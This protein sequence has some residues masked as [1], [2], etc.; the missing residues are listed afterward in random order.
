MTDT[1][2]DSDQIL[3]AARRSLSAQR[4]GGT[5]RLGPG[6]SIGKGS[7]QAK[8]NHW[9]KRG[10]YLVVTLVGLMIATGVFWAVFGPIDFAGVMALALATLVAIGLFAFG[11]SPK[12][13][14]RDEL[15]LGSPQQMVTKTELW[16]ESQRAALPPPAVQIV[17]QL[18]TQLDAL[19]LQLETIDAAHPAMN[20]V[21][22][23]VG[24]YIPET[25]DNYRKI[26]E[27]LREEE[28]AGKTANARLVESL[29]K[30]S[31]EVERVTRRLAEGALDDLA[32]KSRYLDYRY[33]GDDLIGDMRGDDQGAGVPLPDFDAV[34]N[35]VK[36]PR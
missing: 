4:A 20:E 5:H 6:T 29:G 2:G 9:L 25:I 27:H 26:P 21:R 7:A 31:G 18:G 13:P 3:S 14:K 11:P 30:L 22:E 15:K 8:L 19:G 24:E 12:P 16:L 36:A 32:V 10:A 34:S 23:L 17:D 1:T 33:G 28:H 35:P